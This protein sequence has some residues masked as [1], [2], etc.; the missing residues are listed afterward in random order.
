[1]KSPA[2]LPI[3]DALL[4][5]VLVPLGRDKMLSALRHEIRGADFAPVPQLIEDLLRKKYN[6]L[7]SDIKQRHKLAV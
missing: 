5:Q 2:I 6:I 1:M 7:V 3:F 4:L